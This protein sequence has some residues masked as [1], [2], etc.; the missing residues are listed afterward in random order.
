MQMTERKRTPSAA[1][2]YL[3]DG[4]KMQPLPVGVRALLSNVRTHL[5]AFVFLSFLFTGES[6][7][8]EGRS[9][10]LHIILGQ[11]GPPSGEGPTY[12]ENEEGMTHALFVVQEPGLV[13]G[14]L[15]IGQ[16]SWVLPSQDGATALIAQ[17]T[18]ENG[19]RFFE[20]KLPSLE[21]IEGKVW[22]A[23]FKRYV[24]FDASGMW[25]SRPMKMALLGDCILYPT[26]ATEG[27]SPKENAIALNKKNGEVYSFLSGGGRLGSYFSWNDLATVIFPDGSAYLVSFKSGKVEAAPVP[28]SAQRNTAKL[29]PG[30]G[31]FYTNI[32]QST[33]PGRFVGITTQG[34]LNSL[35]LIPT[36][37]LVV[38]QIVQLPS[39]RDPSL[40]S[41]DASSGIAAAS[42]SADKEDENGPFLSSRLLIIDIA[43]GKVLKES[44]VEHLSALQVMGD[45]LLYAVENRLLEIR[46]GEEE[47]AELARVP[48]R[49][50][51]EI[52]PLPLR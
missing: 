34:T 6:W 1:S 2:L 26:L 33:D 51:V 9:W 13:S 5:F 27:E 7:A 42:F 22:N 23:S 28:E 18:V 39:G 40:L 31:E 20:I 19:A 52:F 50:I 15:P 24:S 16:R 35:H 30:T 46:R 25:K 49:R 36:E 21:P 48:A 38:T 43:T 44:T 14:P 29:P 10:L 17:D 32:A 45:S 41:W 4:S 11:E 47:G 37:G 3:F 8:S 12:F